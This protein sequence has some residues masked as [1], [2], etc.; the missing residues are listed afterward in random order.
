MLDNW[1]ATVFCSDKIW[2]ALAGKDKEALLKYASL[3][4]EFA[5]NDGN[6]E[7]RI[8]FHINIAF[9]FGVTGNLKDMKDEY[10]LA[11]NLAKENDLNNFSRRF[12][13]LDLLISKCEGRSL[14]SKNDL[15]DLRESAGRNEQLM[16]DWV[17]SCECHE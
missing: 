4:R 10:L 8:I 16:I 17:E 1:D 13:I 7:L 15:S 2:I 5:N 9:A 3:G 11:S 6:V 12:K 14:N